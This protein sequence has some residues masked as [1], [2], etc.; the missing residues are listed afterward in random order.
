MEKV[1]IYKVTYRIDV[2]HL[3]VNDIEQVAYT[4]FN[5]IDTIVDVLKRRFTDNVK[6]KED[7]IRVDRTNIR[8]V[9]FPTSVKH[10]EHSVLE[11]VKFV[12]TKTNALG[13]CDDKVLFRVLARSFSDAYGIVNMNEELESLL[14]ANK[15][16][17]TK[18]SIVC[19][20]I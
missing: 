9:Y 12:S 5:T 1:D 13:I 6:I 14:P 8:N 3:K 7:S 15:N 4:P 2:P 19:V 20:L 11:V 16:Y 10:G 17:R 18:S